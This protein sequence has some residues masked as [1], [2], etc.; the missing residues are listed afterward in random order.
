MADLP[1]AQRSLIEMPAVRQLLQLGGLAAAIAAALWLVFWSQGQTYATLYSQLSERE[2]AQVVDALTAAGIPHKL[3]GAGGTVT[4][5]ESQVRDARMKLAAAGLP[6]SDALG[7]ELIQKDTGF[8]TSQFMESARYQLAIETE[9]ARTIVKVQGVQSA[10]VHLAIPRQTTFVREHRQPTASVMLQLYPGRRLENGQ[11]AAISHLVA[12]SIPELEASGVTIVDQSGN[13]LSMPEGK[14]PLAISSK[15]LEYTR[16]LE[17]SYAKRIEDML[18]PLA[19]A[20]KVR[21]SVN[22]LLDFTVTEQTSENFDPK[23]QVVRS[24]QT[25][26]DQHSGGDLAV[27]VPG[28]LTN[29]PP[30]TGGA[31]ATP[32][33]PAAAAGAAGAAARAAAAAPTP[34]P[35]TSTSTKETKNYEIDK[36]ISHVLQPTGAIKRLSVAVIVDQKQVKAADGKVTATPLSAKELEDYT[37]VVKD[38]IGFDEKRGDQVQIINA[39]F[40]DPG[41]PAPGEAEPFYANPMVHQIARQALA[42]I[43]VLVLA[44]VVLRPMVKSLLSAPPKAKGRIGGDGGGGAVAGP[45][46]GPQAVAPPPIA[47][48]AQT[49]AYEQQIAAARSLV[50]QDPQRAAQVVK[51]WVASDSR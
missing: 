49:A 42:A 38:A 2:T 27:G 46:G 3:E 51:E 40:T 6:Q 33:A 10:R 24:E 47:V 22:A 21:A 32:P 45:G 7:V 31:P 14:D 41:P 36:T 15:Q 23:T 35:P 9:L 29:Q 12:A 43:L 18:S 39:A 25:S 26:S 13:L 19:G 30:Q 20:G 11:V 4:V 37:T 44:L 28:A 50:A 5:P 16:S 8:G 1:I 48:S 17:Q 34:P